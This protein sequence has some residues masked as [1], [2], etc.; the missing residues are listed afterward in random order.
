MGRYDN[1]G[2]NVT[3]FLGDNSF[4]PQWRCLSKKERCNMNQ[5]LT[6]WQLPE[7]FSH[8]P[9]SSVFKHTKRYFISLSIT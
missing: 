1:S 7:I 2:S 5:Y 3:G 6:C 4:L 9:H 8:I